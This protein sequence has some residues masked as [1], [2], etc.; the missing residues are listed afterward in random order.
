MPFGKKP[1]S[2]SSLPMTGGVRRSFSGGE[3]LTPPPYR[4]L[5]AQTAPEAF[6]PP[7]TSREFNPSL[8]TGNWSHQHLRYCRGSKS[9]L[10]WWETE[11]WSGMTDADI[12]FFFFFQLKNSFSLVFGSHFT[13]MSNQ[14]RI[15][16]LLQATFELQIQVKLWFQF[17]ELWDNLYCFMVSLKWLNVLHCRILRDLTWG[18]NMP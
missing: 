11:A 10:G 6:P 5:P 12:K 17:M 15:F 13:K 9:G 2:L 7:R 8:K 18:R 16:I 1:V 3:E 4:T 14:G